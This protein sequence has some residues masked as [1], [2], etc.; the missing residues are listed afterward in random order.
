LNNEIVKNVPRLGWLID[1]NQATPDV[2]VMLFDAGDR[3]TLTIPFKGELQSGQAGVGYGPYAEWFF[4][5]GRATGGRSMQMGRCPRTLMFQDVDGPVALVGCRSSGFEFGSFSG[6]GTVVPDYCVLGAGNLKYERINGMSTEIHGL[7]YWLGLGRTEYQNDRDAAGRVVAGVVRTEIAEPVPLH[8]HLDLTLKHSWSAASPD[9]SGRFTGQVGWDIETTNEEDRPWEEHLALHQALRQLLTVATWRE[10]RFTSMRVR[11]NDDPATVMTGKPVG[12]QWNPVVTYRVP[13]T[14]ASVKQGPS[15]IKYEDI[16]QKGIKRWLHLCEELPDAIHLLVMLR[17][18]RSHY[19]ETAL[20][21][22]SIALENLAYW[23]ALKEPGSPQIAKSGRLTT[24]RNGLALIQQKVPVGV[25]P[26]W[27]QWIKDSNGSY[28]A[29]KH[30]D[31]PM[32]SELTRYNAWRQNALVLRAWIATYLGVRS[33]VLVG[34]LPTD[35][36]YTPY[37]SA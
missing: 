22:T 12:P 10:T 33:D 2:A 30:K 34:R 13:M 31:R 35:P 3:I 20:L 32:P 17:D 28:M 4:P 21:N 1:G 18:G 5:S 16:G 14:A 27:D 15:L 36:L 25:L 37:E 26:N 6:S 9:R 23:L 29:T 19:L 11:R 24:F 7:N 8:H